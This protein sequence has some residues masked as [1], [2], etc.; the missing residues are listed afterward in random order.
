MAEYVR[1]DP[2]AR[3]D[4]MREKET[5]T[6]GSC[7]W[8]GQVRWRK[9]RKGEKTTMYLYRYHVAMDGGH[10]YYDQHLFCSGSCRKTYYA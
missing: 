8:C 10:V 5:I 1:R 7:A 6:G 9:N 2:F 4:L 3:L